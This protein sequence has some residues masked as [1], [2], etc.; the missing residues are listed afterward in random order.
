MRLLQRSLRNFKNSSVDFTF[1]HSFHTSCNND[2]FCP[3]C[4]NKFCD[5]CEPNIIAA[6]LKRIC[7]CLE[8]A[9]NL[10]IHRCPGPNNGIHFLR[11]PRRRTRMMHTSCLRKLSWN[12]P[13]WPSA[14]YWTLYEGEPGNSHLANWRTL[15]GH[16]P[17]L[18]KLVSTAPLACWARRLLLRSKARNSN[19]D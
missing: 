3:H 19:F 10:N 17:H 5:E 6:F 1:C 9:I 13:F 4:S 2:A 7:Y 16:S 14:K 12:T 11:N 18:S 15:E 8:I